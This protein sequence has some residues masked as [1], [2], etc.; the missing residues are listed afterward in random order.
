MC[1]YTSCKA[2]T[3]M[4]F[5]IFV[6][7]TTFLLFKMKWNFEGW[8][9]MIGF[10]GFSKSSKRSGFMFF[11]QILILTRVSH[12]I[13]ISYFQINTFKLFFHLIYLCRFRKWTF[14]KCRE[15]NFSLHLLQ[16]KGLI[17]KCSTIICVHAH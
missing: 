14:K 11:Y 13:M 17:F 1:A 2:K 8:I 12:S 6:H 10:W 15:K 9:E 4:S 3:N 7:K 5:W 16:E